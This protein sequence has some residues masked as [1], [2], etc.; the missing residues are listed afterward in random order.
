MSNDSIR[1]IHP[2]GISALF[3]L[4]R[5]E[6]PISWRAFGVGVALASFMDQEGKCWPSRGAIADRAGID[7]RAVTRGFRELGVIA[8]KESKN[9]PFGKGNPSERAYKD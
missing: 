4:R 8:P 3:R 5:W 1:F 6:K 9:S 2:E 7:L